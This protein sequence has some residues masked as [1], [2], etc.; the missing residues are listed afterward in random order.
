MR[1]DASKE[2]ASAARDYV[3]MV[4]GKFDPKGVED[5]L[6][7][8][9]RGATARDAATLWNLGAIGPYEFRQRLGE[10][11]AE[12][13]GSA[14]LKKKGVD[15]SNTGARDYLWDEIVAREGK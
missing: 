13:L 4:S 11:V 1:A 12:L 14:L 9:M 8:A 5:A 2:L 10:R 3:T 7:L 6:D 15:F